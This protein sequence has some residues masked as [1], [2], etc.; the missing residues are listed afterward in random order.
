[1]ADEVDLLSAGRLEYLI[2]EVGHEGCGRVDV[3]AGLCSFHQRM[4][5]WV[6][7]ERVG[8]ESGCFEAGSVVRPR[9]EGVFGRARDEHDRVGAL[10]WLAGEVVGARNLGTGVLFR[11]PDCRG[12]TGHAWPLDT[13][14]DSVGAVRCA[15]P[16]WMVGGDVGR[17]TGEGGGRCAHGNRHRGKEGRE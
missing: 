7:V 4:C 14:G 15:N 10:P 8:A 11:K 5:F 12:P 9:D 1:M 16:A 3:A 13:G 17:W 2:D 6:V